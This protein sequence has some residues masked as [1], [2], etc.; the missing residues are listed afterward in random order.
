MTVATEQLDW[1]RP[2]PGEHLVIEPA[3]WELYE[4]LL[5]HADWQH[6]RIT[7]DQGKLVAM[8]PLLIHERWKKLI[9][10]MIE[11]M[12]EERNIPIASASQT[13]WRRRMLRRGLEADEC[14]F[15]Q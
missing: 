8:S 12:T 13:T 11:A 4:R 9:G 3:S 7:Y 5:N 6:V 10:R 1:V 2:E 15:V 14:Y